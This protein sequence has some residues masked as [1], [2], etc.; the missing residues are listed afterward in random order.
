[1]ATARTSARPGRR[2]DRSPRRGD[3]RT[4]ARFPRPCV[5]SGSPSRERLVRRHPMN[6][7]S[8]LRVIETRR[9]ARAVLFAAL[10]LAP[11]CGGGAGSPTGASAAVVDNVQP[12]HVDLGPAG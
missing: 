2:A 7:T 4:H 10:L 6:A 12:V 5:S 3:G 9:T 11:A 8:R 1:A